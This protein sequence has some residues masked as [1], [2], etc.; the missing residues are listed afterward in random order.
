MLAEGDVRPEP[1]PVPMNRSRGSPHAEQHLE[2][3]LLRL[4]A[5]LADESLAPPRRPLVVVA[6]L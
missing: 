3:G 6:I 2:L 5:M 1:M 4:Q